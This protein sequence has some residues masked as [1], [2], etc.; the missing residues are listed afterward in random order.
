MDNF[1]GTLTPTSSPGNEDRLNT[2]GTVNGT[3][4]NATGNV[5]QTVNQQ[6]QRGRRG[7]PFV[8]ILNLALGPLDLNLLG[9]VVHLNQVVLNITAE[10]GPG[11]LLG[12]L[13]ARWRT[14]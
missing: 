7:R 9:L 11:N 1:A 10:G 14:C 8:P 4:T 3:L 12:N 2:L 13:C 6:M 5:R